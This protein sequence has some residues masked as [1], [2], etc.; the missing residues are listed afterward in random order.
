MRLSKK[1][2]ELQNKPSLLKLLPPEVISELQAGLYAGKPLVGKDGLLAPMIKELVELSLQGEM[3]SHLDES[4]LEEGSNRRNGIATKTVK[5]SVGSFDLGVPRDRNSS[6]EPEIV[7]KR[8][9]ILSDELDNKILSLYAIG[10]SYEDISRHISDIYGLEVSDAKISSITDK[11]IPR[12]T[13]WR[14]RPLEAKYSIVFLDAMFFKVKQD[15]K[16]QTKAIYNIM[17]IDMSGRKDILGF[18]GCESEGAHFWLGVLN[19]LKARGIGDILIA[20]IDGLKGFPEAINAAF[21]K[22]EIQTCIVH[23]IRNS[24][25]YVASKNARDFMRDL[26]GVYQADTKD[27]AEHNLLILDEKWGSKYPMVIKSWQ[28]NWD[29]LSTYFKFSKEIRKLIYTT[30]PIEGFHRQVRKYTKTKGAFTSDN[31]LFKLLFCA[32]D[33]ITDKWTMPIPNWAMT[34]SQLDIYFPARVLFGE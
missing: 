26:K 9:T 14:N 24:L 15:N 31:A 19:D 30:N 11:L 21:P 12:L 4:N 16:I 5:S 34:I 3:D 23:Q 17:G 10:S 33:Q 8:Q 25:K 29:N 28:E 6:F 20:C 2:K 22:T 27:M 18:Y 13:A 7:K 1:Q 32:I